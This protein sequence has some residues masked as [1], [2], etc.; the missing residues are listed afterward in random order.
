M[1][2]HLRVNLPIQL[3]CNVTEGCWKMLSKSTSVGQD[4]IYRASARSRSF[5]MHRRRRDG[6]GGHAA[7]DANNDWSAGA[8]SMR[9]CYTSIIRTTIDS[10]ERGEIASGAQRG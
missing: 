6:R 3:L 1:L 7:S 5:E 8:L 4:G 2:L 9:V 10:I